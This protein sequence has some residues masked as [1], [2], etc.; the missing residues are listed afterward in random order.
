MALKFEVENLDS[1]PES[2]RGEYA[3]HTD[4]AGKKT[5][6]LALDLPDGLAVENVAGLKSALQKE[7]T[8]AGDTAKELA[9]LRESLNGVDVASLQGELKTLREQSQ[10]SQ[11][12]LE[13][14]IAS[15]QI[16]AAIAQ[17]RGNQELLAPVLEKRTRV[18]DGVVAVIGDDG[19]VRDG[20]T[21]SDLVAE[22]R[23]NDVYSG[24]FAGTG[25]SGG[26]A[27]GGDGSG[28]G[29]KP[30]AYKRRSAMSLQEKASAIR[31]L[32]T[33]GFMSLPA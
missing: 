1:I 24:A 10:A 14:A 17:H 13:A 18:V 31:E 9:K 32:G 33:D 6:K 7:R 23:G 12:R 28:G 29:G 16:S 30:A 5:F 3:E 27:T 4:A 8:N 11:G 20:V 22:M 15:A 26:G 21:V 25:K 19:K 2:L